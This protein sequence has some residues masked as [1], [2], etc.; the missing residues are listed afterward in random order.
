MAPA[1]DLNA[2]HLADDA[3]QQTFQAWR[4]EFGQH[5]QR[6]LFVAFEQCAALLS[7]VV[8]NQQLFD[9]SQIVVG[10]GSLEHLLDYGPLPLE[11]RRPLME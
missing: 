5:P 4:L 11:L 2:E 9:A 1:F 10:R 3:T 8:G 7:N 6:F